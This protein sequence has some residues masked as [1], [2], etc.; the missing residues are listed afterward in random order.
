[1]DYESPKIDLIKWENGLNKLVEDFDEIN[2]QKHCHPYQQLYQYME[3]IITE[4]IKIQWYIINLLNQWKSAQQKSIITGRIDMSIFDDIQRCNT[5]IIKFYLNF[6]MINENFNEWFSNLSHKIGNQLQLLLQNAFIVIE[7]PCSNILKH[8][9]LTIISNAK[10]EVK[11]GLLFGYQLEWLESFDMRLLAED[12]IRLV[13]DEGLEAIRPRKSSFNIIN[14]VEP[15]LNIENEIL[16]ITITSNLKVDI[17]R[18][19]H[20]PKAVPVT[21]NK[22]KFIFWLNIDMSGLKFTLHTFS[23]P[24]NVLS[25]KDYRNSYATIFWDNAFAIENRKMFE[26]RS[27][28][29]WPELAIVLNQ[30]FCKDVGV[31]LSEE[32]LNFIRTMIP[33]GNEYNNDVITWEQFAKTPLPMRHFTFFEWFYKILILVRDHLKQLFI[34]GLIHGFISPEMSEKLLQ[35]CIDGTFLIRF[36]VTFCGAI[37]VAYVQNRKFDKLLPWDLERLKK[38]S[39]SHTIKSADFLLYLYPNIPK[40]DVF[41]KYYVHNNNMIRSITGKDYS[42][43]T[44]IATQ[45]LPTNNI[46]QASNKV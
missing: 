20:N 15:I 25:R 36:S 35:G 42:C 18:R 9:P 46:E 10:F 33:S 41:G 4:I 14:K 28:V 1:M 27:S 6:L 32:H 3:Q 7:Q 39:V 30:K 22:F 24:I 23:L 44:D 13:I 19:G 17:N 21:E 38:M 37:T 8:D 43:D 5:I 40:N 34:D 31:F 16:T 29:S 26:T 2:R 11:I 45:I 12:E